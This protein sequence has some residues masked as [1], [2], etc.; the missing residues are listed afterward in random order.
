MC[1]WPSVGIKFVRDNLFPVRAVCQLLMLKNIAWTQRKFW[2]HP[3]DR[4]HSPDQL[5]KTGDWGDVAVA[6]SSHGDDY[7][8]EGRGDGG[9]A[10]LGVRALLYL[11]EV[12][13]TG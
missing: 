8:V 1:F 2:S 10:G 3:G 12:A 9:E 4:T 6:D 13:E 11:N 5:S 7:P